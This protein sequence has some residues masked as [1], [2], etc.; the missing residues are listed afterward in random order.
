MKESERIGYQLE[1]SFEGDAWHGSA[2]LE[3]LEGVTL[4]QA[5]RRPI[6]DA[7]TIA[8]IVR[9]MITW[10]RVVTRR[11]GGHA[12]SEVPPGV[13]WPPAAIGSLP[14]WRALVTQ[15][16]RAHA[17]LVA[18]AKK[19]GDETLDRAPAHGV[20]TRYV[21]LHGIIQHDL[22]H[23]GQIALLKKA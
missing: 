13:D 16:K 23:A 6:A 3:L 12:V 15:L 5:R 17:A 18:A 10:K 7:H 14:Q 20:T 8:E 22:Y 1:R 21:L 19:V 9:H 2:V 4:A 11:L